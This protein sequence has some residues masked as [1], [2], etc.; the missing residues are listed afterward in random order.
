MIARIITAEICV[1]CRR[2][3]L[4]MITETNLHKKGSRNNLLNVS[5]QLSCNFISNHKKNVYLCDNCNVL[6]VLFCSLASSS[7]PV[8]YRVGGKYFNGKKILDKCQT[9]G[10]RL[11]RINN[12]NTLGEVKNIIKSNT[13]RYWTGLR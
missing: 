1:F 5:L 13:Q 2:R 6:H 3:K 8:T 7:Q 4:R 11:A 9:S 12:N 10:E